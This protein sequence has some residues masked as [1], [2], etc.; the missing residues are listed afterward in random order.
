MTLRD[1][2]IAEEAQAR[3]PARVLDIA[4]AHGPNWSLANIGAEVSSIDPIGRPTPYTDVRRCDVNSETLP[5][6]DGEIDIVTMGCVLAHLS[7][8]LKFLKEVHR[9]LAPGGTLILMSPNPNYYWENI[10]NIFYNH[11]KGR[12]SKSKHVEHFYE[13]TR[14]TMRTLLER[15]GFTLEKEIGATFAIMK[16]NIRLDVS[17]YPGLAYE[18]IYVARKTGTP[19]PFTVIEDEKG[20]ILNLKTDLF[21]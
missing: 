7:K 4:Y 1:E 9:V 2:I 13:F 5:F 17:K 11:F 12:V 6:G 16:T 21:S 15:S 19:E 14:Y 20:A 10:L 8:P 18:I 3:H